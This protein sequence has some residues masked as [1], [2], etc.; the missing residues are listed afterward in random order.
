MQRWRSREVVDRGVVVGCGDGCGKGVRKRK[1]KKKK[2]MMMMKEVR[3]GVGSVGVLMTTGLH[4]LESVVEIKTTT[5]TMTTKHFRRFGSGAAVMM[6][7]REDEGEGSEN[8]LLP[9]LL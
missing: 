5:T 2:M 8:L 4:C 3:F 7:M 9:C 6:E 1:K